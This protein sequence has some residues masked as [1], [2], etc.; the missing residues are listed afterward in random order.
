MTKPFS[1]ACENNK[2]P[3]L[4]VI[5]RYFRDG[6]TVLEVG[7]YTTQHIRFFAT[8]LPGVTWQPSDTPE[9]MP[10]VSAGLEGVSLANILPPLALDVTQEQWPVAGVDGIFSANT[11]HIMPEANMAYFFRGAGRVLNPGGTLCVYGPFKYAG[12]YTSESNAGF[13]E[14]LR[15]RDPDSGIRDFE[16]ADALARKA[17]LNFVEDHAMPANNQLIAWRKMGPE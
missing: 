14:W 3:I 16:A 13:Q 2:A 11:L 10:L 15:A 17:G 8:K 9:S 6:D 12:E 4:A 1:Q 5:E 7:S